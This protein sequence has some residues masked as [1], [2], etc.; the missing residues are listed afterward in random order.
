MS[1][2]ISAPEADCRGFPM[3]ALKQLLQDIEDQ[4]GWH[5]TFK[6]KTLCDAKPDVYGLPGTAMRRAVQNKTQRLKKLSRVAYLELLV[7][8]GINAFPHQRQRGLLHLQ[9][10]SK[11][12]VVG[13]KPQQLKTLLQ[14]I[15]SNGGLHGVVGLKTICNRK[16]DVYGR[17]GTTERRVIQ[18][19]VHHLKLLNRVDY[20]QMLLDM[21]I[22]TENP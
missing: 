3:E 10:S 9:D 5:E 20:L 16:P 11:P 2:V 4:G 15:E 22:Q 21:G 17:P 8:L 12:R 7:S 1:S 18:N 14:D 6:L 13:I 19:K